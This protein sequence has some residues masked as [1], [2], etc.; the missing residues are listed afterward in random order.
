MSP[1]RPRLTR[2]TELL[3]EYK[4]SGYAQTP[5]LL[6]R[7]DGRMLEVS[8]LLH[9]VAA[10]IDGTRDLGQ[11]AA[12]V[13]DESGRTI[14]AENIAYLIEHK[15]RPLGVMTGADAD[16]EP[17]PPRSPILGMTLRTV[18]IPTPVVRAATTVLRPLFHPLVVAAALAG[19][20]ALDAWLLFGPG[21]GSGLRAVLYTPGLLVV[22]ALLTVLGGALHEL[23]HATGSRYGGAE[24]GVIGAGIYLLWPAF[25]NDLN[26]SYRLSRA[27]RLR[28]DLGGVYFNALFMLALAG[29]YGLT[30]FQPLLVVIALQNLEILQQFLPFLRLDG[31]YIVSDA[32]GV[33][34]LF[35]R[36]RPILSGLV[37]GRR[38]APAVAGLKRGARLVVT[39]WVLVTVP[40]LVGSLVLLG[41]RL[42]DL[43]AVAIDS[44]A[45]QARSLAAALQTGD[46]IRVLLS[47]LHLAVLIIPLIGITLTLLRALRRCLSSGARSGFSGD[48]STRRAHGIGGERPGRNHVEALR[49]PP[50]SGDGGGTGAERVSPDGPPSATARALSSL[51]YVVFPGI[52]GLACLRGATR[53]PDD[54]VWRWLGGWCLVW[55]AGGA[56]WTF[57]AV[58]RDKRHPFAPVGGAP[59]G[60]PS[61]PSGSDRR[62]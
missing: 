8:H 33:P 3:G 43:L 45:I 31:Y 36:I 50:P 13:T 4:G 29:V 62:P 27:G 52:A 21:I 38:A 37:P 2:G 46:V 47:A 19:T 1:V 48:G 44:G 58:V 54:G 57:Y 23:G 25:F 32:A 14:S 10:S 34:D 56:L 5:Y 42:P 40:L 60:R 30:G 59:S 28:A 11:V 55:A 18:V 7:A 22:V 12:R 9:L 51:S 41:I 26:D 20:V 49:R 24:P 39:I 16:P 35:G 53:H 6:R 61:L 15:L 17:V